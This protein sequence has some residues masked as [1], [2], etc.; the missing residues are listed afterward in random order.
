MVSKFANHYPDA[1]PSAAN[2]FEAA[3]SVCNA[4]TLLKDAAHNTI[5]RG[6]WVEGD[7]GIC[8]IISSERQN[9][10][11]FIAQQM[12]STDRLYRPLK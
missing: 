8:V 10:I 1:N 6:W 2:K 9:L 12:Y 5:L 7:K 3:E 11:T 4:C